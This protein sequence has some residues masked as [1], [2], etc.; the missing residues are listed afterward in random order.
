MSRSVTMP[1]SRPS[2]LVTG[3]SRMCCFSMRLRA[4]KMGIEGG[5]VVT[6]PVISSRTIMTLAPFRGIQQR[7]GGALKT[8]D[9]REHLLD[10]ATHVVEVGAKVKLGTQRFLVVEHDVRAARGSLSLRGGEAPAIDTLAVERDLGGAGEL[11]LREA[12]DQGAGR[13]AP[14]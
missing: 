13:F 12:P 14:D 4:S 8:M 9:E 3:R 2:A 10:R 1:S 5:A 6:A 11:D 7:G